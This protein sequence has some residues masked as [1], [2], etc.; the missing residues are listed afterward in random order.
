MRGS[1]GN[2]SVRSGKLFVHV[3]PSEQSHD[4]ISLKDFCVGN[5]IQEVEGGP[6]SALAFYRD[7]VATN[8]PAIFRN[9]VHHWPAIRKWS[10]DYL[11]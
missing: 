9:A 1:P 3:L 11:G 4:A 6:E 10:D 7:F 5:S 2:A 8:R